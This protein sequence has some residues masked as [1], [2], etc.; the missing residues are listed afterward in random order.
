MESTLQAQRDWWNGFT[1][2]EKW[3]MARSKQ[4]AKLRLSDV[5]EMFKNSIK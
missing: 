1:E 4:F 5:Y 3:F 2:D